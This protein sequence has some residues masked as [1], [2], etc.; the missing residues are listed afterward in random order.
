MPVK[1]ILLFTYFIFSFFAVAQVSFQPNEIKQTF[2]WSSAGD[3]LKY[4]ITIKRIDKKSINSK[5][6]FYHETTEEETKNC[7]IYIDP[8]LPAGKYSAT[9]KVY[10]LLGILEEACTSSNEFTIYKAYQPEVH[11][12]EYLLNKQS[13]IYLD[14][15]DN[16]GIVQINGR[17]L[18]ET[19]ETKESLTY[20]DYFLTN[21]HLIIKPEEIISYSE[22]NRRTVMKFNMKKLHVGKYYLVARDASGLHSE[23]TTSSTLNVKFKKWIDIDIKAGYTLPVLLHDDTITNYFGTNCFPLSAFVGVSIMPVKC[24]WGYLGIG[25]RGS[26]SRADGSGAD[27][28]IDGNLIFLHGLLI[29]QKPFLNR[30]LIT[31]LHAG[32]GITYFNNYVFHY[33]HNIDSIPLNTVSLSFDAGIAIQIFFN[34]RLFTEISTDYVFTLNKDILMGNLQPSIAIGWQF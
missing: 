16:D 1:F 22:N 32:A 12:V 4:E 23:C 19:D 10:N 11:D 26:Y 13:V 9:I 29:F 18:F 6:H 2:S 14:D 28:T 17:N 7:Q 31:E 21:G 30:R 5:E 3:V 27:Y 33:Q 24:S 20:T 8:S 15:P 25:L 34:R